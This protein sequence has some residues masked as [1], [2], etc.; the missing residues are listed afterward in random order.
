V[1]NKSIEP[2]RLD[3]ENEQLL[4]EANLT[5]AIGEAVMGK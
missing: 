5:P 4:N 3:M 2:V 1:L